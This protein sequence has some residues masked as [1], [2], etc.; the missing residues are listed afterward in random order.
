[1]NRRALFT[2]LL[3]H[4]CVGCCLG[5][6]K[7]QVIDQDS[8]GIVLKADSPDQ[9][10]I[11]IENVG[12]DDA[13]FS[14]KL[15]GQFFKSTDDVIQAIQRFENAV[16]N[17]PIQ[18]KTW[19]FVCASIAYNLPLV[20]NHWQQSPLILLN[21]IGYD[22]CG[23]QAEL[24]AFLWRKLGFD[25]RIWSLK[26]HIVPEVFADGR[27]QMFDPSNQV[28]Y[29]N[30][31]GKVASVEELANTPALITNPVQKVSLNLNSVNKSILESVSHSNFLASIYASVDNN[32]VYSPNFLGDTSVTEFAL[33][34]PPA[35]V[36]DFP[37]F[38]PNLPQPKFRF[39][40]YNSANARLKIPKNWIGQ[41]NLPLVIASIAG[42]GIIKVNDKKFVVGSADL[43]D[44]L[45]AFSEFNY[46]VEVDGSQGEIEI[47]YLINGSFS[48]LKT[49]NQLE[50]VSTNTRSLAV[51]IESLDSMYYLSQATSQL[52]TKNLTDLL[53]ALESHNERLT[54]LIGKNKIRSWSDVSRK[55]AKMISFLNQVGYPV[56]IASELIVAKIAE[57]ERTMKPKF[58]VVFFEFLHEPRNFMLFVAFLCSHSADEINLLTKELLQKN[59]TK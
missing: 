6:E 51:T 3:L 54:K 29:L 57:L 37:L 34:L 44:Y 19:R 27:W 16:D 25:T 13:V 46:R 10:R 24:L 8:I 55:T 14:F 58:A 5:Q 33:R 45:T 26:G 1:M 43:N 42:E 49:Y 4:F 48:S 36:F 21:S 23:N 11:R 17:E 41:I 20:Q 2:S 47:I 22:K 31:H 53:F 35:A 50:V 15:N 56:P 52:F 32:Y 28:Y 39:L 12:L 9:Q 59:K 30:Q 40:D 18:Q 7:S 38:Y